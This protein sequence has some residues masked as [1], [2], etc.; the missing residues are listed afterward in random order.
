MGQFQRC[1]D[2]GAI[3]LD[4]E[5]D[6]L[7][8]KDAR[9]G[10]LRHSRRRGRL[11]GDRAVHDRASVLDATLAR[12]AIAPESQAIAI[13]GGRVVAYRCTSAWPVAMRLSNIHLRYVQC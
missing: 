7:D 5:W 1:A 13:A 11:C 3:E 9:T 10:T 8:A 4:L 12:R 6:G 2:R